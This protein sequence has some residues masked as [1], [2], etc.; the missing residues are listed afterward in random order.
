MVKPQASNPELAIWRD[1]NHG[2]EW[3]RQGT[4]V[5]GAKEGSAYRHEKRAKLGRKEGRKGQKIEGSKG[6]NQGQSK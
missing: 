4:G 1:E 2:C 6:W 5:V 3:L